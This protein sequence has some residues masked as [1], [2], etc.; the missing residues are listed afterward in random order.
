M[1]YMAKRDVLFFLKGKKDQSCCW[2]KKFQKA[3]TGSRETSKAAFSDPGGSGKRAGTGY[4]R[5]L[6][7][8]DLL[9]DCLKGRLRKTERL[10]REE[11]VWG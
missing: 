7:A 6:W 11:L 8:Q 2:A 3:K 5:R 1:T 9:A 4:T 10:R